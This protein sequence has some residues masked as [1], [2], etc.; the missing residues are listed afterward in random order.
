MRNE[1][2]VDSSNNYFK[3]AEKK[4]FYESKSLS[5]IMAFL[6][7]LSFSAAYDNRGFTTRRCG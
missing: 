3:S 5:A 6:S 4:F 1:C 2:R 7:I